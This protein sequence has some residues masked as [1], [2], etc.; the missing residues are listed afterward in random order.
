MLKGYDSVTK[1]LNSNNELMTLI[2]Q[3]S[4]SNKQEK[5]DLEKKI[6][7]ILGSIFYSRNDLVGIHVMTNDGNIYSF[8]RIQGAK[9]RQNYDSKEYNKIIQL[10]GEISWLGVY[11]LS[12]MSDDYE[13][14]VFAFG[15]QLFDLSSLKPVGAVLIEAD[16]FAI[17][18]AL[19]N[20]SLS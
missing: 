3:S 13:G 16:V 20:A 5:I 2:Q 1:S 18:S 4:K 14:E 19:L 9:V 11:P 7:D 12:I 15:R 10:A 8:E 17:H 6:T